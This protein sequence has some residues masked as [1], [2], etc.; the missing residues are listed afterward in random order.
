MFLSKC[1]WT[2][3]L[4]AILG[5]QLGL[6]ALADDLLVTQTEFFPSV[7]ENF[8]VYFSFFKSFDFYQQCSLALVV[9]LFGIPRNWSVFTQVYFIL[10]RSAVNNF[11]IL[12]NKL[13][14]FIMATELIDEMLPPLKK[15]SRIKTQTHMN[16][17]QHKD[18]KV[19]VWI[20]DCPPHPP[21]L[22]D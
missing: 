2:F 19:W 21:P 1:P 15:N 5:M 8:S 17:W 9:L 22:G 20:S 3:S 12:Y 18:G 13:D 7:K 4:S 10:I 16:S 6:L 14:D 11:S